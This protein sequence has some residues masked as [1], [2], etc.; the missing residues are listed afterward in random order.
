MA[1]YDPEGWDLYDPDWTQFEGCWR[2]ELSN[3]EMVLWIPLYWEWMN[4]FGWGQWWRRW[5]W[6]SRLGV[7]PRWMPLREGDFDGYKILNG[8]RHDDKIF[9][10]FR[11]EPWKMLRQ[12]H[13]SYS[14]H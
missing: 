1:A 10:P 3:G 9:V 2:H 5:R 12:K 7:L 13:I 14:S 6:Y 8:V 11:S 4:A